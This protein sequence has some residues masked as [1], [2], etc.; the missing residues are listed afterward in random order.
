MFSNLQSYL[1]GREVGGWPIHTMRTGTA[2]LFGVQ[3]TIQLFYVAA[4]T[5]LRESG[6]SGRAGGALLFPAHRKA[7]IGGPKKGVLSSPPARPRSLPGRWPQCPAAPRLAGW[8]WEGSRL[9]RWAGR[10]VPRTSRSASPC[11]T[12]RCMTRRHERRRRPR[13]ADASAGKRPAGC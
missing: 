7:R 10:S 8:T 11:R 5:K 3:T 6:S 4:S 13:A 9:G 1:S 12:P 2:S